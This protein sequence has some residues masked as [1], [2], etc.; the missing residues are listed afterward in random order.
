MQLIYSKL[1]FA[2]SISH[3]YTFDLQSEADKSHGDFAHDLESRVFAHMTLKPFCKANMLRSK[4]RE[5]CLSICLQ[6][7]PC[8]HI[9]LEKNLYL[10][11]E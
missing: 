4:R 3:S 1:H 7:W 8:V 9:Q 5:N 11:L 10:G 6:P 2:L